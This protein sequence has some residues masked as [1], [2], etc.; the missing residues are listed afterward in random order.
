MKIL[1]SETA[2]METQDRKAAA[3]KAALKAKIG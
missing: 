2:Q 1:D 3:A